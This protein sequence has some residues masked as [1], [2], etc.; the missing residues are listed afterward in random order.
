M[1]NRNLQP[2]GRNQGFSLIELL[3]VI[4]IIVLLAAVLIPVV[5]KARNSSRA[6][7]TLAQMQRIQQGCEHYYSDFNAYPGPISDTLLD[8]VTHFTGAQNLFVGL[9]RRFFPAVPGNPY[10]TS[11]VIAGLGNFC[12]DQ[13]PGDQLANYS[14]HNPWGNLN[15]SIGGVSYNTFDAYIVPKPNE[16]ST[17]AQSAQSSG[18]DLVQYPAFVDGA[19]GN[20]ARPILYYRQAYKFDGEIQTKAI[21]NPAIVLNTPFAATLVENMPSDGQACFYANSNTLI[22]KDG[23]IPTKNT[24]APGTKLAGFVTQTISGVQVPAGGFVLISPGVDRI[25]GTSDDL[26]VAGGH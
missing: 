14:V 6:A 23:T 12:V 11:A 1:A 20:E 15:S 2:R 24:A 7:A 3:V 4:A 10:T 8:G 25:Y 13:N 18:L 22:D 16:V 9:S 26:V 19:F 5:S 17:A 21:T